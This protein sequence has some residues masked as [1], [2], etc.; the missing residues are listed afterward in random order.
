MD[1]IF[2][3]KKTIFY[4]LLTLDYFYYIRPTKKPNMKNLFVI[5]TLALCLTAS[6]TF[7]QD[8]KTTPKAAKKEVK[9]EKAKAEMKPA[10]AA[11][12]EVKAE[13]KEEKAK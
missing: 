6:S 4:L 11:K 1:K 9:A 8:M 5:A 2:G 7:A 3:R 10:K 13:K 12:K